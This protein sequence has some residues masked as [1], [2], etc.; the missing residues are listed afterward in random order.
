MRK[1]IAPLILF[2]AVSNWLLAGGGTAPEIDA[3]SATAALGLVGGAVMLI[4]SHK[5]K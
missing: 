5:K 2:D 4:Q 3:G 1:L